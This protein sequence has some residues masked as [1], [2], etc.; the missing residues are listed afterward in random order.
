MTIPKLFDSFDSD[1]KFLILHAFHNY[2]KDELK[3]AGVLVQF[4][5]INV[6]KYNVSNLIC[7]FNLYC[8][9]ITVIICMHCSYSKN[10]IPDR[11]TSF[12][13]IHYYAYEYALCEPNQLRGVYFCLSH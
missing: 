8:T 13:R 10:L 6:K 11:P 3:Y 2:K 9:D 12:C 1:Q 4:T 5:K 7:K